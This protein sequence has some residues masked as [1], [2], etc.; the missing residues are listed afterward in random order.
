MVELQNEV[1]A[2]L[3]SLGGRT[4]TWLYLKY[5]HGATKLFS[6]PN[7][8]GSIASQVVHAHMAGRMCA[9]SAG[10]MHAPLAKKS[11]QLPAS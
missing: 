11:G 8:T 10:A 2:L 4:S 3:R 1:L 6:A 5:A 9:V 7:A